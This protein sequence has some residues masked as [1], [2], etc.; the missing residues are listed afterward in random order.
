VG[1]G[2]RPRSVRVICRFFH[3]TYIATPHPRSVTGELIQTPRDVVPPKG[4]H[5]ANLG[6][7]HFPWRPAG[8]RAPARDQDVVPSKGAHCAKSGALQGPGLRAAAGSVSGSAAV[9]SRRTTAR[10]ARSGTS[11]VLRNPLKSASWRSSAPLASCRT[12]RQSLPNSSLTPGSGQV[13]PCLCFSSPAN[14][15]AR[16]RASLGAGLPRASGRRS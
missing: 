14:S 16:F 5:C 9:V 15:T 7:L 13:K 10:P 11:S 8:W 12:A 6:A 1:H 3:R 2:P 4:A